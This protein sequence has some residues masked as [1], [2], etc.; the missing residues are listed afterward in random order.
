MPKKKVEF[1]F[2]N[3]L[4]CEA[5]E[6]SELFQQESEPL[7]FFFLLLFSDSVF[8]G[9][10]STSSPVTHNIPPRLLHSQYLFFILPVFCLFFGGSGQP[11]EKKNPL[12]WDH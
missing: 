7:V 4:F 1:L 2:I 8:S 12:N 5:A 10:S 6:T 11:D 3:K 9:V